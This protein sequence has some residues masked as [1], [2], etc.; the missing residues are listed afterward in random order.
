MRLFKMF[1][2]LMIRLWVGVIGF[3]LWSRFI[4]ISLEAD[5][6]WGVI[7]LLK[8]TF[9]L[10][11]LPLLRAFLLSINI[12]MQNL[13]ILKIEG[14]GDLSQTEC[15]IYSDIDQLIRR[16]LTTAISTQ[17]QNPNS[18]I[19]VKF[20]DQA[21]ALQLASLRFFLS[22][23]NEPGIHWLPLYL[24]DENFVDFIPDQIDLPRVLIDI[25]PTMIDPVIDFTESSEYEEGENST[26]VKIEP[27]NVELMIKVTELENSLNLFRRNSEM[28]IE[29]TV[30][31]YQEQI[32]SLTG[33]LETSQRLLSSKEDLLSSVLS[34]NEMLKLSLE[35]MINER[36]ELQS[37][38]V[39]L[40]RLY[41]SFHKYSGLSEKT[42]KCEV[43]QMEG[44][45]VESQEGFSKGQ[46][47]VLSSRLAENEGKMRKLKG[48]QEIDE[49]VKGVLRVL[50][51]DGFMKLADEA[52]FMV[53][54]KKVNVF[55]K[56]N[57]V[58]VRCGG[59][60]KTLEAFIGSSCGNELQ[61]FMKCRKSLCSS[62]GNY[63][64]RMTPQTDPEKIHNSVINKSFECGLFPIM[65][66]KSRSIGKPKM[67]V[68]FKKIGQT[69]RPRV[70]N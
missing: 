1:F 57:V 45:L 12:Q 24:T 30:F 65:L 46:I 7:N 62:P 55:V 38:V 31:S 25:H 34:E 33:Q 8:S 15:V 19:L 70:Y 41:E 66:Q 16:P 17:I 51:I 64:K 9:A 42:Q 37:K 20:Q 21:S 63:P 35:K 6:V 22:V 44:V 27:Q 52:V 53:G 49:K 11:N 36:N 58:Q 47:F 56:K 5:S 40:E 3:L 18:C 4:F 43:V 29:E 26:P 39:K 32:W 48:I 10:I 2:D 13:T 28:Q 67:G 68:S 23:F 60:F 50:G 61:G 59:F 14:L 54:G 69:L